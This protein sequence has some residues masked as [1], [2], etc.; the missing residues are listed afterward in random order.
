MALRGGDERVT[1]SVDARVLL[2]AFVAASLTALAT[3]LGALPFMFGRPIAKRWMA[4]AWAF[5]GGLMVAVSVL[6]L[7]LPAFQSG[8]LGAVAGG[9][10]LGVVPFWYAS[11]WMHERQTGLAG[12]PSLGT[13]RIVIVVGVLT[14]HSFPEGV[15]VGV[16]YGSGEAALGLTVAIAIA[17]HNIPEGIAVSIPLY[18]EGTRGWRLPGWSVFSSLPQPLMAVPAALA[19]TLFER[20]LPAAFAVAAGA[21]L[22]LVVTEMLPASVQEGASRREAGWALAAGV[23]AMA[24]LRELF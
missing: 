20:L 15:A 21:M 9:I 12:W 14:V 6:D 3:G 7:L 11:R 10:A 22:F 4:R 5:A 1:S 17:I 23:A 18:S 24:L 8:S 2:E 19:V 16:A 13:A